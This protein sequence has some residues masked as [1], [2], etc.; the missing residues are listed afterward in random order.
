MFIIVSFFTWFVML[1]TNIWNETI[2]QQ[3][4]VSQL[5]SQYNRLIFHLLCFSSLEQST[6]RLSYPLSQTSSTNLSHSSIHHLLA[7]SLSLSLSLCISASLQA[8]D[9]SLP[10]IIPA[11]VCLHI[12]IVGSLVH[13]TWLYSHFISLLLSLY[14]SYYLISSAIRPI[15]VQ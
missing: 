6:W 7:L 4:F 13:S 2:I 3:Y 9:S 5:S 10:P 8:Q 15:I 14:H 12:Y 11:L 1:K